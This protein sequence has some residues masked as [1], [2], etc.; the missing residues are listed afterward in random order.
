MLK[1]DTI[2]TL[3]PELEVDLFEDYPE[4]VL[5]CEWNPALEQ[6]IR[7]RKH[8]LEPAEHQWLYAYQ[9]DLPTITY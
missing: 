4:E 6:V 7:L 5:V 1:H 2:P 9:P 8:R 3:T